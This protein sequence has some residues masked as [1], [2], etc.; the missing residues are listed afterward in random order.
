MHI[1]ALSARTREALDDTIARFRT[2]LERNPSQAADIAYTANAGRTHFHHRLAITGRDMLEMREKLAAGTFVK[3][4]ERQVCGKVA[5]LF[6]GQGSQWPG[7]C[8]ELYDTQAVF[9][10]ALDDCAGRLRLEKP[11]LDVVYGRDSALLDQTAYTQPALFSIEWALAQLWKS[12]GIEPDVVLG[13]SVG[14]YAALCAAGLWTLDDGLRLIAERGRLMQALGPGWGMIAVQADV[15]RVQGALHGMEPFVSIA[16]RNAPASTVVSGRASEL[17]EVQRRLT[18]TG[19][20]SVRLTVSH[21]FHSSQMQGVADDF[22]I[23]AR[24]VPTHSPRCNIVSSVTGGFAGQE[25]LSDG[26]YWRRQVR[27]AVEFKAGMET[28]AAAGYDLF[29]EVGPAAVLCGLGRKCIGADGQLWAPSIRRERGAWDQMLD[30][31]AQL[32]VRGAEVD[33]AGFDAPYRRRRVVL[34]TYPFQRQRYWIEPGKTKTAGHPLP[35]ERI[36]VDGEGIA[37]RPIEAAFL[38][39]QQSDD[40]LFRLEWVEQQSAQPPHGSPG[41]AGYWL[42]LTGDAAAGPE[43]ASLLQSQGLQCGTLRMGSEFRQTGPAD[44]SVRPDNADD[45]GRAL[46]LMNRHTALKCAGI[47]HLWS[48]DV[49]SGFGGEVPPGS[50]RTACASISAL[51]RAFDSRSS[52][53]R[54]RVWLVTS[55]AVAIGGEADISLFQAP[56]WGLGRVL[57]HEHPELWGGLADLD[58]SASPVDCARFL[59]DEIQRPGGDDQVAMRGASR[60]AA[61]LKRFRPAVRP[62]PGWR[63]DGAYL[64]TGGFGGIG[65]AVACRL[66]RDGAK[67]IALV[68]RTELP[69]RSK[70]P[71]IDADSP[72]GRMVAIVRDLESLGIA[73]HFSACD[74]ADEEAVVRLAGQLRDRDWPPVRGIFHAAGVVEKKSIAESTSADLSR[75]SRAKVEGAWALHR[76]FEHEP[77]DCFVLFSSGAALL[78]PPNL[79]AYAS[80]NAFLD[81]LALY[82]AARGLPALSINWGAW[83]ETGMAARFAV[84]NVR[85]LAE[86]G[87]VSLTTEQGLEALERLLA[88]SAAQVAVLPMDWSHWRR[89]A[90]IVLGGLLAEVVPPQETGARLEFDWQTFL[91]A[92]RD[93]RVVTI[94]NYLVDLVSRVLGFQSAELETGQPLTALGLDS[95]TALEIRNAV[96][97][98]LGISVSLRVLFEASHLGALARQLETVAWL[99]KGCGHGPESSESR[100]EFVL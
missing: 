17:A 8:R 39:A 88:S 71:E 33:W 29:V 60:Y 13:H 5:F 42:V 49:A 37:G 70:W 19:A 83:S 45:F 74:V 63:A 31:L 73:V 47:L 52:D 21:G 35:G 58:P 62:F 2:N 94:N 57:A 72:I 100:E 43:V 4:E 86:H 7:M 6:T 53:I 9:R 92:G 16:A 89:S 69:E 27:N 68:G 97:R 75:V 78:G 48:L 46:D 98:D 10:E 36:A 96:Q 3:G 38:P 80:A 56:V 67:F 22:A 79:G 28:L 41:T 51:T 50:H 55:G 40:W 61:R 20:K 81:A 15:D 18:A 44:F 93:E 77:L 65:G 14:E 84:G 85:S 66:A 59:V 34:P 11:L 23:L 24:Q 26:A 87:M 99:Q 76:A 25:E 54:P 82:R 30:S 64:I 12:W 32:Y 95:L 1:L 90:D 91:A